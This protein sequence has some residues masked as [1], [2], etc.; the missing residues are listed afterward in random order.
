MECENLNYSN[1]SL[2][3]YL[4]IGESIDC[5]QQLFLIKKKNF[6]GIF[7]KI[8]TSTIP[9]DINLNDNNISSKIIFNAYENLIN[10][11]SSIKIKILD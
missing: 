2:I 5:Y 3:N 8:F 6:D 10:G 1:S 7:C 9:G 4:G 11:V